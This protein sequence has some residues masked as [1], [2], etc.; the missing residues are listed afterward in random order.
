[1]VAFGHWHGSFVAWY[2]DLVLVN[3]S[4]VSLTFDGA[5]AATLA[6]LQWHGD[7]WTAQHLRVPYDPSPELRRARERELPPHP[8]WEQ[9]AAR[10]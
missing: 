2:G 6:V 10:A 7:H 1:M 8:W 3:V 4:P 9:L 5:P